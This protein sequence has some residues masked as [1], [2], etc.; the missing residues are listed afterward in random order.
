ME[1]PLH[2][3]THPQ[4]SAGCWTHAPKIGIAWGLV[5]VLVLVFFLNHLLDEVNSG[6]IAGLCVSLASYGTSTLFITLMFVKG[7][8]KKIPTA[9][10]C[11]LS[12]LFSLAFAMVIGHWVHSF[13]AYLND[14]S[15]GEV[16][17]VRSDNHSSF[18]SLYSSCHL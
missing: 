17:A 6:Y 9:R 7:A 13:V 8:R 1:E 15:S 5:S 3:R 4:C 12:L 14:P 2:S 11:L 16:G 18:D 10:L